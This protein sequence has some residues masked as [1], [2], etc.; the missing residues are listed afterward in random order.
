MYA[1]NIIATISDH[2]PQ[3]L[4]ALNVLSKAPC[5]KSNSYER[6]WSKFLLYLIGPNFVFDYY[7]KDWSD[8]F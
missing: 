5:H 8:V 7:E 4:F 3:F 2:L 1:G 6:D